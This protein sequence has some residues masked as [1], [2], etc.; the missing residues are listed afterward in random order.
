M[1]LEARW[2]IQHNKKENKSY[3]WTDYTPDSLLDRY[4]LAKVEVRRNGEE[5]IILDA[6]AYN[7]LIQTVEKNIQKALDSVLKSFE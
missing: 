1:T 5:R 3:E 7:E 6:D 4:I 2:N